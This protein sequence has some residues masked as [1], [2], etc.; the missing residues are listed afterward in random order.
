M[1]LYGP[2]VRVHEWL[3]EQKPER[4][5]SVL[6]VNM[7]TFREWVRGYGVLCGLGVLH[8]S[9]NGPEPNSYPADRKPT[10]PND[11]DV[12]AVSENGG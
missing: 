1:T 4:C 6:F 9:V 11:V 7:N 2:R 5:A 10:Y 8:N 12:D 3:S